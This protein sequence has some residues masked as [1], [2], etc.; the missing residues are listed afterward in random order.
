LD[1]C[2]ADILAV[3]YSYDLRQFVEVAGW[4]SLPAD[5]LLLTGLPFLTNR[6][7][8]PKQAR[9]QRILYADQPTVPARAAE[10][11]YIYRQLVDYALDH[12]DRE[13]LLKPRHR[14][15]EDTFHRMRHHP[16]NVLSGVDLPA[17]FRIDYTSIQDQLATTDLLITMSST[18]SLE[19]LDRGCRVA[20]LLDLG[21]HERHGNQVFLNSGLLR[22]FT[23]IRRDDLGIAD[24]HW[25]G[26]Y[27]PG[28]GR[29]SSTIIA[30]RIDQLLL[31]GERPAAAVWETDYF[32]SA[33]RF[34]R[35]SSEAPAGPLRLRAWERRRADHG[36][37]LGS[38]LH[39]AHSVS[40]PLITAF[41]RRA[42]LRAVPRRGQPLKGAPM[43]SRT[44]SQRMI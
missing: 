24:P 16:A 25:L 20:L 44:W 13:V 35:E 12:P 37:L 39:F 18:A 29:S 22:T 30:D 19:A 9:I 15:G 28:L 36:R 2:G 42:K 3:N 31:S 7:D 40:P 34:R 5:N 1:R 8:E 26:S 4:L 41:A 32:R 33:A 10:R 27:F 38:A 6:A 11:A 14:L 23:Q 17:N 43:I 21:I